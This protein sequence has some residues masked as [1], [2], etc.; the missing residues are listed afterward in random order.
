MRFKEGERVFGRVAQNK[1]GAFAEYVAVREDYVTKMPAS[2]DFESAAGIPLA[3][4]TAL[5]CL[6]D[7]LAVRPGQRIFISWGAGGVGI[8]AIQLAKWFGAEVA[9]TASPE[10]EALV[11]SLDAD[12]VIDYTRERIN[13]II[14]DFAGALDL[15]GGSTLAN[16]FGIVKPGRKV[17]S[18][19]GRPDP[20]PITALKD[21]HSR[22][23]LAV[24]FL[25]SSLPIHLLVLAH[26]VFYRYVFVHPGG[27]DLSELAGL[28]DRGKLKPA[29][30]RIFPFGEI[31]QAFA[32][33][34]AGHAK[35]KVIVKMVDCTDLTPAGT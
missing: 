1:M 26:G 23:D 28:V 3:G 4:L 16:T 31:D 29:V 6:R 8:F 13:T 21:P 12:W 14:H 22:I 2:L 18:I 15:V 19:A 11:R 24:L 35:G 7:V 9:T 25:F 5:Q 30:D 20:D 32:Y 10:V 33:L 17:V 27:S 34:E